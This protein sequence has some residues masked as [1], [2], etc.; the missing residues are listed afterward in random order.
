MKKILFSFILSASFFLTQAQTPADSLLI[1]SSAVEVDT[2]S[3]SLM[4]DMLTE[5]PALLPERMIFTQRWIYG[6]KGLLRATGLVPLTLEDRQKEMKVRRF[7]LVS[8]QVVG[9]ATL[10]SMLGTAT[11]GILLYNNMITKDIHEGFVSFTNAG[12]IAG[13][14]LA[15]LAPPALIS[16]SGG[17]WDSID[18]HKFFAVM[19]ISGMIAT[20]ILSDYASQGGNWKL[21]HG[22]SG[23]FTALTFTAAFVSIK[24]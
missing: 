10:A 19:H 2:T 23:G 14:A 21:A 24:F 6:E 12:Y 20:N 1:D 8:H 16:R 22:I 5:T 17:K 3:L 15:F 7:M 18:W 11:T 13:A 9:Y 4:D